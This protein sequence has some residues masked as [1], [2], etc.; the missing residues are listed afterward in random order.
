MRPQARAGSTDEA[1][2]RYLT[3]KREQSEEGLI[4]VTMSGVYAP[5]VMASEAI[6]GLNMSINNLSMGGCTVNATILN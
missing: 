4:T 5:Y 3:F 6:K 2:D 1:I